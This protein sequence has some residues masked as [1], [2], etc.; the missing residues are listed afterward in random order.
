MPDSRRI[1]VSA[2]ASAQG[3]NQLW[4]ASTVTGGYY[5]LTS[6]I[7]DRINPRV[8]PDGRV[9]LFTETLSNFDVVSATLDSASV[10][11]LVATERNEQMPAWAAKQWV[12]VYVTDR[13]GPLEIWMRSGE[14][15]RPLVTAKDFAPGTTRSL[16]GPALAPDASRV[17][18][19]RVDTKGGTSGMRLWISAVNGSAPTLLTNDSLDL[20]A[21]GCWSPDAAWFAYYAMGSGKQDL[22]KA[23]TTGQATPILVKAGVNGGA[24][25]PSWSPDGKWICVGEQLVSPDG[26]STRSLPK[27]TSPAY[28]FSADGKRMYG[29]RQDGERQL[30]FSI[31]LA[32]GKEK[33]V[34]DLGKDFRPDSSLGPGIRFSLAPDGKS[35]IYGVRND[36]SNLWL[37]EGFEPKTDLLS[38]LGLR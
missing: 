6:G 19:A 11:R 28:M 14:V 35:F 25:L 7:S 29:I 22:M 32:T 12:M 15:D 23:K 30:L 24:S 33:V 17:I 3:S 20:E 34:G 1:V 38:R 26:K 37:L 5:A 27:D 36:K 31:D 10:H 16:L 18:Y 13:N 8:S 4:M 9:I 21:P 2:Q